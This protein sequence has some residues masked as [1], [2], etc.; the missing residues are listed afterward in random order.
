MKK[1]IKKS[2]DWSIIASVMVLLYFLIVKYQEPPAWKMSM[3]DVSSE[4][5]LK[6]GY[7]IDIYNTIVVILISLIVFWI[8][9]VLIFY[10]FQQ[11]RRAIQ[12]IVNERKLTD[13]VWLNNET[14]I[15]F[16]S[17]N[18]FIRIDDQNIVKGKWE[19]FEKNKTTILVTIGNEDYV[20]E[21][22]DNTILEKQTGNFYEPSSSNK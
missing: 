10:I 5:N 1:I 7:R 4:S 3:W 19:Y 6:Y 8:C 22:I 16:K 13:V 17:P 14:K 15:R 9:F 11:S 2:L 21:Y 20:Y 18:E 12:P